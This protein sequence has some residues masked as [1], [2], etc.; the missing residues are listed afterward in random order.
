MIGD[1]PLFGAFQNI[2]TNLSFNKTYGAT[3]V[4]GVKTA[5]TDTELDKLLN[6]KSFLADTLNV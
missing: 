6:P 4:K 5:S 1:P 2:F 3:G